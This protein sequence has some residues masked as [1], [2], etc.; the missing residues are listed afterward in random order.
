MDNTQKKVAATAGGA[1]AAAVAVALSAALLSGGAT[2]EFTMD[3]SFSNPNEYTQILVLNEPDTFKADIT[4]LYLNGQLV[5]ECVLP[6]GELTSIPVVFT[7][8]QN[9]SLKFYKRGEDV[10]S[11]T[12]LRD[13][14]LLV[15]C[16]ENVYE[17]E[18]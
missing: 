3:Y 12:F 18:E 16:D 1:G 15:T 11:G 4:E 14:T 6:Y 13:G 2:A 5:T 7:D 8:M 10:G 9:C 17:V